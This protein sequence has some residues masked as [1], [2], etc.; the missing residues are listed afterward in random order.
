[1]KPWM[2]GIFTLVLAVFNGHSSPSFSPW[3][4]LGGRGL[5]NAASYLNWVMCQSHSHPPEQAQIGHSEF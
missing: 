5:G 3:C 1:V 4:R 2:S